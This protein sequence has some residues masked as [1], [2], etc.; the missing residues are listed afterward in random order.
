MNNPTRD[1]KTIFGRAQE[2]A[3][4]DERAAYLDQ[5]CGSDV[6]LRAEVESL[7][8]ALARA[9]DFLSKPVA[10]QAV[11][12]PPL[13]EGPGSRIGPYRL[14]QQLGEGGMGVVYLAEQQEP[15]RRALALK[16]IKPGMD[17]AQV[18]AR[19]EVERQALAL[20]DHPNIARVY[21]AGT[22]ASGRPYF[23]M[24]LVHGAPITQYCDENRLS[25]RERLELFVPVCQAIQHAHQKGIIHRD[26]KPSNVLV[27]LADGKPVPKVID[28]GVAKAVAQPLPEQT[29]LTQWGAVV[30]TL[31]YMAPEQAE[32]SAQGVDTRSDIYSLGVLLYELLTG[33]TPLERQRLRQAALG[34]I[35]R[36]IQEEEPPRPSARLSDSGERL[37]EVSAQRRMEPAQ[38]TKLVRGELDWI[39]MKALEKDRARRYETASGLA[40]DLQRYLQDEPVEA[41]PPSAGY[42]LRKF[43][44]K[45]R[46]ALLT[47]AAFVGVLVAAVAVSTWQAVQATV[48]QEAAVKARDAEAV[49][50]KRA[51]E[52]A[53]AATR[54][55]ANAQ[56]AR[57]DAQRLARE[58]K[59]A[60]LRAESTRHALQISLALAAWE[61]NDLLEAERVLGTVDAA[62][63]QTWESRHLRELCRRKA[64]LVTSAGGVPFSVGW[65]GAG[66]GRFVPTE[67]AKTPLFP[68]HCLAISPDGQRIA[69]W[70]LA[71]TVEVWD[72][73]TGEVKAT[74]KGHTHSIGSVAFSPDGRLIASG[75]DD[76]TIKVWDAATGEERLTF[77]AHAG[78]VRGLAFRGDGCRFASC[79]RGVKGRPGEVKVWDAETGQPQL[80]IEVP[81]RKD[82]RA[83]RGPDLLAGG[84]AVAFSR[85]GRQLAAAIMDT[86]ATVWDALTGEAKLAFPGPGPEVTSLAFSGD[87]QYLAV[88]SIDAT[89]RL[90][91]VAMSQEK[92]L[93][94]TDSPADALP[95]FSCTG[96]A[97]SNDGLH[98]AAAD[99]NGTVRVWEVA[100]G[101]QKLV[102]K[103]HKLATRVAFSGDG[104]RLV[105][106]SVLDNVSHVRMWNN[107]TLT[108]DLSKIPLK[109]EARVWDLEVKPGALLLKGQALGSVALGSTGQYFVSADTGGT[110]RVWDTVT[111]QAGHSFTPPKGAAR[112]VAVSA[113]GQRIALGGSNG[114]VRMWDAAMGQQRLSFA[115]HTAA[116][117][118][119]VFS[120]NGRALASTM[121]AQGNKASEWRVWDAATG[122]PRFS[123]KAPGGQL[124]RL[125]FSPDG[126]HLATVG[127]DRLVRVWDAA[128]GREQ[129]TLTH[130]TVR[131][132]LGTYAGCVAFSPRGHRLVTAM[133]DDA[134]KVWDVRARRQILTLDGHFGVVAGAV[135]SPDGQR[136]VS[137]GRDR[138]VRLWDAATGQEMLRLSIPH[139]AAGVAFSADGQRIVAAGMDGTVTVWEAPLRDPR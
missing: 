73:A 51:T 11:G 94:K 135:F 117:W 7:L 110:V 137:A 64:R 82:A 50:R 32:A 116:V 120:P 132:P 16:I 42:R 119:L 54:E 34:E 70:S 91:N 112:S 68:L 118:N 111:G 83:F 60:R 58:E 45:H 114:T 128:T 98:F 103:G 20:M 130:S 92:P 75:G 8:Q 134:L 19:F 40:H 2:L 49:E 3:A 87:G 56:R 71:R 17:S 5:T 109:S 28:F 99:T 43:A 78:A 38:L 24:E 72:A 25:P 44:R 123:L 59:A 105:S 102:L 74:L 125:A 14:L 18:I 129:F 97:F 126:Q 127:A 22:T 1:A 131:L 84:V 23:V 106:A 21:D 104:R 12:P 15:L 13:V 93:F 89:V 41:C 107:A 86:R 69:A 90:W 139:P 108:E 65:F 57:D 76:G 77:K 47:A 55:A 138:T 95:D 62:Y 37:P 53:S 122:Q 36:L 26:L 6:E 10:P 79:C 80:A 31:E 35:L 29:L 136:I 101:R 133:D 121:F 100:T 81:V 124:L 88:G 30:G 96:V 46:T 66:E 115:A 39:V 85:D 52:A 9:G 33:T 67:G 27:T 113:D 61:R 63:R 48:A 4:P